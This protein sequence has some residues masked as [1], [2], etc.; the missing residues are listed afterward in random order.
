MISPQENEL[1]VVLGHTC[2]CFLYKWFPPQGKK[3]T[4]CVVL[5]HVCPPWAKGVTPMPANLMFTDPWKGFFAVCVIRH[6]MSSVTAP[7]T[8]RVALATAAVDT[9]GTWHR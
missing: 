9:V 2:V 8:A 5:L 1:F 3:R 6:F 7:V 4:V